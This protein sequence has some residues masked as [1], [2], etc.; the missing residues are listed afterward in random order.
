MGHVRL[1]LLQGTSQ[2]LSGS[3]CLPTNLAGPQQLQ[4]G[5]SSSETREKEEA[6]QVEA[7]SMYSDL[8][9]RGDINPSMP[10]SLIYSFAWAVVT[11]SH[12]LAV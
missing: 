3:V 7:G 10:I 8:G 5:M 11:E 9:F 1:G 2:V 12:R 6:V 4:L